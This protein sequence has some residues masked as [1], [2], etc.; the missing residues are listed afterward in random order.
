MFLFLFAGVVFPSWFATFAS[1]W[2]QCI[3]LKWFIVE[4]F[5]ILTIIFYCSVFLSNGHTV[6]SLWK[7]CRNF[8]EK[9]DPNGWELWPFLLDLLFVLSFQ[10]P[11]WSRHIELFTIPECILAYLL[12]GTIC[13]FEGACN[14]FDVKCP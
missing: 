5:F 14:P 13:D 7:F 10:M 11:Y 3:A 4:F 6:F 1:N 12:S 9:C 8:A 2:K